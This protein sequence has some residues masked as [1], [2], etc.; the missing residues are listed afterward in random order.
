MKKKQIV[1]LKKYINDAKKCF[2]EYDSL[3]DK[4]KAYDTYC[5]LLDYYE[6]VTGINVCNQ[7]EEYVSNEIKNLHQSLTNHAL[8]D[9]VKYKE[10][11]KRITKSSVLKLDSV[12]QEVADSSYLSSV[13]T[14]SYYRLSK[15]ENR[16]NWE[17]FFQYLGKHKELKDLYFKICHNHNC[18]FSRNEAHSFFA[19][20]Y[21]L[22]EYLLLIGKG[23]SSLDT[24][25]DIVHELGHAS[26]YQY[27]VDIN[28]VFGKLEFMQENLFS[29]V[30]SSYFEQE[31]LEYYL[32]HTSQ[33][34]EGVLKAMD[35]F[36]NCEG[37]LYMI[38]SASS[39]DDE[40]IY[41][42]EGKD[43]FVDDKKIV[44]DIDVD[45]F[46]RRFVYEDS[47]IL[48][49]YGFLISS[50]LLEHPEKIDCFLEMRR[51]EFSPQLLE[52][53]GIREDNVCDIIDSRCQKVFGKYL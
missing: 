12:L 10:Y 40:S 48:Y 34:V 2:F 18:Y 31:F 36:D 9:L 52:E 53:L 7:L 27:D 14:D 43:S 37:K 25:V 20:D 23:N 28:H 30:M 35:F 21:L 42:L 41:Q 13:D 22:E 39:L 32:K 5:T 47:A 15:E 50:Y 29:E 17:L 16:E 11:H 26:E 19:V 6:A 38:F 24:V 44:E 46:D 3:E 45:C 1:M 33:K 49:G 8:D 4:V 51:E